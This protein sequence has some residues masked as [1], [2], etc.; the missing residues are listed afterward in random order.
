MPLPAIIPAIAP[1]V[2]GG[3]FSAKG[4]SDANAANAAE[5]ARNRAFQERM[6]N[7]A[8][9]RRMADLKE[10]G[11]NP[12]LAGKF[13]ASS[14]AGNMAQMGNVGAA[15]VEGAAKGATTAATTAS[16]SVIR[17]QAK[18]IAAQT[19]LTDAQA[20]VLGGPAAAGEATGDL[21]NWIKR[22]ITDVDYKNL[23]QQFKID[24]EKAGGS[25]Q[26]TAK[27]LNPIAAFKRWYEKK[28]KTPSKYDAV[29]RGGQTR[30]N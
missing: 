10:G 15:G 19:R 3:L 5:A 16:L 30:K 4:Q 17:N 8:I 29:I 14:P 18:Q 12:I 25:A 26:S 9:Q 6:S 28:L 22:N 1:A 13:D 23:Y 7:T 21:L 20:R 27:E 2:I 24:M 11:L